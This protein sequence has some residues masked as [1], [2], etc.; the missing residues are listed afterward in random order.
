MGKGYRTKIN[1]VYEEDAK[2]WFTYE[3]IG[4]SV[5]PLCM[6]ACGKTLY[7]HEI[8]TY[9]IVGLMMI[10]C[11]ECLPEYCKEHDIPLED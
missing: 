9:Y 6:G 5:M 4:F 7:T 2:S 10:V 1:G 8:D 11:Q 3:V